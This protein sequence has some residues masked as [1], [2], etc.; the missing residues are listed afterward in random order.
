MIKQC[1]HYF[2]QPFIFEQGFYMEH[3]N[4]RKTEKFALGSPYTM[5]WYSLYNK[6]I[7]VSPIYERKQYLL[8]IIVISKQ[9][10]GLVDTTADFLNVDIENMYIHFGL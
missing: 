2:I 4:H 3:Y 7:D 8:C 1:I 6:S 5:F 9:V 10:I